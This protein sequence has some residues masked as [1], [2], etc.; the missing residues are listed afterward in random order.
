MY[1]NY[2][3]SASCYRRGKNDKFEKSKESTFVTPIFVL[4]LRNFSGEFLSVVKRSECFTTEIKKK[5]QSKPNTLIFTNACMSFYSR[6]ILL[7]TTVCG[8]GTHC[9]S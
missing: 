5:I 2:Q 9:C 4:L 8:S 1:K 7:Q 3:D 6:L